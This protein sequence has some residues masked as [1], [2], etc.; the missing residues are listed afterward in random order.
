MQMTR[1]ML[2]AKGKM[3]LSRGFIQQHLEPFS[4]HHSIETQG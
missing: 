3:V 4:S 1:H 2:K